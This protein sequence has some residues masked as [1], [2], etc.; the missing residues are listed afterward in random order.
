VVDARAVKVVESVRL[1]RKMLWE[2]VLEWLGPKEESAVN[3]SRVSI[4]SKSIKSRSI[5][6]PI[7]YNNNMAS[8]RSITYSHASNR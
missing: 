8:A 4:K 5:K 3:V 2:Y 6:E 1:Q 7:T